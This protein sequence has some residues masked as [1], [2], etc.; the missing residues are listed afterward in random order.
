MAIREML[1]RL[2]GNLFMA[3]V[4]DIAASREAAAQIHH[5]GFGGNFG[6]TGGDAELHLGNRADK[7]CRERE[8]HGRSVGHPDD[9]FAHGVARDE[10][11]INGPQRPELAAGC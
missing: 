6:K 1:I 3:I 4:L 11:L 10:V 5:D 2:L 8:G 7:S 9:D